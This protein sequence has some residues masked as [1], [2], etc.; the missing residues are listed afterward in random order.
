MTAVNTRIEYMY[1]DG[2]NYKTHGHVVLPGRLTPEQ[3]ETL[4]ERVDGEFI[5]QQVGLAPLFGDWSSHYED[6][7]PWH[8]LT[9]VEE[10]VAPVNT[11]RI[12]TEG[13]V[14]PA[15]EWAARFLTVERW[16]P[17]LAAED[18]DTWVAETPVGR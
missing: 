10:T 2:S 12:L 13:A 9:W 17:T 5:P 3:R 6:D 18:F 4:T 7:H 1:R 16:D 11:D 8:E 15:T 14:P